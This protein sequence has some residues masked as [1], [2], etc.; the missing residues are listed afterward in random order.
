[1]GGVVFDLRIDLGGL[2][3]FVDFWV[4]V[5]FL[6]MMLGVWGGRGVLDY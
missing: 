3:M 4:G 1:V 6:K 5:I 2:R